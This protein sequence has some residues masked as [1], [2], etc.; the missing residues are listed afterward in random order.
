MSKVEF[1]QE[2]QRFV[3]WS[4]IALAFW[5]KAAADPRG[6][7]AEDLT[8]D[9]RANFDTTRRVRVQSRQAYVYAHAGYLG[10]FEG[11]KA[12]SD[13]A[14]N[15]VMGPG[16]A[17]GEF[18]ASETRWGCAHL[19]AGDG[20]LVNDMRDTYAQAFILLSGAWR[21]RAFQ[22]EKALAAAVNTLEF[23]QENLSSDHGGWF[24][25]LP[26]P[27]S[28]ERRQNPHMHLFEAFIGLYNATQ[29]P[30]FLGLA[31]DMFRLFEMHFFDPK[32]GNLWEFFE[33]DWSLKGDGGP[34]EPGHM[35]EWAWLLA[36]YSEISGKDVQS[37]IVKLYEAAMA[38]GYDK[39]LGLICDMVSL[40]ET[41]IERTFRTWPQTEMIKASIARAK[42]EGSDAM[43]AAAAK[44][45][46]ALF[47][48]YLSVDVAGGW[49]DKVSLSGEP[50]SSVMP[51]STFYHLF[52]AAAE[53]DA[54][55]SRVS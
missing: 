6:G 4:K 39:D 30:R 15:F 51:T 25:A 11:A 7:Y 26:L 9:G 10:W 16:S 55:M 41:P 54:L 17:G 21:Y 32:T 29:S 38:T 40:D 23:L 42:I 50:L 3:D 2:A 14:W 12:A 18:I 47:D 36:A 46:R 48:H 19:V 31:D 13:Q 49:I 20:R 28:T 34:V 24:E 45:I 1:I 44:G 52:C 5:A 53:A 37:Y 33:P 35:M 43:Y 8:M 27:E 22:D